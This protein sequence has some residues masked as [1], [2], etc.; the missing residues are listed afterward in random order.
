MKFVV[1]S[2]KGFAV[3]TAERRTIRRSEA[4]ERERAEV[5]ESV[6]FAGRLY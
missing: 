3:R 2:L 1:T 5:V 4:S 6:T